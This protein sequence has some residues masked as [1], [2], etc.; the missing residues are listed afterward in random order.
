[1]EEEINSS[2]NNDKPLSYGGKYRLYQFYN[3]KNVDLTDYYIF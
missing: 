2:F 3:K 1:M